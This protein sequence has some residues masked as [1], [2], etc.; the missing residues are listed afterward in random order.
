[1]PV[2]LI[3]VVV[4]RMRADNLHVGRMHPVVGVRERQHSWRNSMRRHEE[5][6]SL[7]PFGH[8]PRPAG[9]PEV[10]PGVEVDRGAGL[11][12]EN[13]LRR[14][15]DRRR[16]WDDDHRWGL[17]SDDDGRPR[18]WRRPDADADAEVAGGRG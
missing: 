9:K 8:E 4:P 13:R 18:W 7:V 12:D 14:N 10:L 3:V 5:P 16:L 15:D 1:M 6:G 17:G 11:D 2:A